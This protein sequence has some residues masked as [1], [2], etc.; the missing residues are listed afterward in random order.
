MFV[1]SQARFQSCLQAMDDAEFNYLYEALKKDHVDIYNK[2]VQGSKDPQ[3]EQ[4]TRQIKREVKQW[5]RTKILAQ[6]IMEAQSMKPKPKPKPKPMDPRNEE[7]KDTEEQY[8]EVK[9]KDGYEKTNLKTYTR[10][11]TKDGYTTTAPEIHSRRTGPTNTYPEPPA[12]AAPTHPQPGYSKPSSRPESPAYSTYSSSSESSPYSSSSEPPTR[13]EA[14]A[15]SQHNDGGSRYQGSAYKTTGGSKVELSTPRDARNEHGARR[16]GQ[17]RAKGNQK[18][19]RGSKDRGEVQVRYSKSKNKEL[20][21]S[22][23][24]QR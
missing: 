1:Q 14:P 2:V 5:A 7:N 13:P 3:L 18:I 8:K 9:P 24:K 4:V 10:T 16:S 22:R 11:G 12:N 19:D 17:E 21:M 15:Y 23:S 20:F 6:N